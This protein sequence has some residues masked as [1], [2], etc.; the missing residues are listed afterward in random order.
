MRWAIAAGLAGGVLLWLASP[1]VGLGWLAWIAL[2]PPA[3]VAISDPTGR[4]GRLAVPLAYTVALELLLVPALPFGLADGQF[5][6]LPA[7]LF[8]DGSPVLLVALL[9]V[10]LFGLL[11]WAVRFGQP[12]IVV[13]LPVVAWAGLDFLRVK[14][15]PGASWG[16]LFLT[17][18]D[19]PTASLA[20]LGGAP[21][22]TLAIALVGY[23]TALALVRRTRGA[24]VALAAVVAAVAVATFVGD[25]V[26]GDGGD[27]VTVAAVQPGEHSA[28]D[29]V[30]PF[31][32]FAPG[33]YELAASDVI[34]DL[35][36]LTEEAAARGA[37]VVAWPEAMAYVDPTQV[38]AAR[39]E[40]LELARRTGAAIV[41]PYFIRADRQ[42]EAVVVSPAGEISEPLPK[43]RPRW[44][45][46]EDGGNRVAPRTVDVAGITIGTLLGV[47]NEDLSVA[48]RLA[49]AGADLLVSS[50]HDW[51]ELAVMQRAF[52]HVAAAAIGIP[53]VR[54]DWR[55]GSAVI[56]ADGTDAAAPSTAKS[57]RVVVADV[58]VRSGSTPYMVLGDTVGW[59]CAAVG[60]VLWLIALT[61]SARRRAPRPLPQQAP[62]ASQPRR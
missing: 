34:A 37:E 13:A 62:T 53:V 9:L 33:S 43:Q 59:L 56:D 24:G 46:D 28:A 20:A 11:L 22:V 32:R 51:R 55:Y 58:R 12:W 29:D 45:W 7:P 35:T 44:F 17:Q 19:L 27:T 26:R 10:P 25:R 14:L 8:I 50:T 39:A 3:A 40:L 47:D 54:A 52:S 30:F 38:P 49:D 4:A 57:R 36:P 23:T 21:A 1:A 15:D 48:R 60:L 2:V 18:H 5:G 16:P 31:Q 41:V 6:E 42:G 61:R